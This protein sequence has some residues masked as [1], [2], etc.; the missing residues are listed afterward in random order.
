MGVD[1]KKARP[2]SVFDDLPL[3]G[4]EKQLRVFI[5]FHDEL[6]D[7][8]ECYLTAVSI[9]GD[10]SYEALSYAS[11]D[12]NIASFTTVQGQPYRVTINAHAAF[13]QLRQKSTPRVL[14]IDVICIN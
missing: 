12:P 6:D 4:E 9:N 5:L 3:L 13:L 2:L 14:W 1:E 8:I 7:S 11:G 10:M